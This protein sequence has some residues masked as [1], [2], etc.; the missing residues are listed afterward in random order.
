MGAGRVATFALGG[1]HK[2]GHRM[3]YEE[4]FERVKIDVSELE[5]RVRELEREVERLAALLDKKED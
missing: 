1:Y 3:I 2:G 4:D 5:D